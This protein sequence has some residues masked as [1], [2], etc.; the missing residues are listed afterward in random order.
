M[1]GAQHTGQGPPLAFVLILLANIVVGVANLRFAKYLR[2]YRV[3]LMRGRRIQEG[4]SRI[5][6][7]NI[8]GLGHYDPKGQKLVRWLWFGLGLQVA[9]VNSV[10]VFL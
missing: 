8:L 2:R 10:W 5:A 1:Q 4:S 7:F 6:A 3:D 9:V